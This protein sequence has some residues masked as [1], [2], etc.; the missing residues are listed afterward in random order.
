MESKEVRCGRNYSQQKRGIAAGHMRVVD[1]ISS[2][3]LA[4]VSCSL[5][6]P[7]PDNSFVCVNSLQLLFC[8]T[9]VSS[10]RIKI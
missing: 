4:K 6:L 5:A 9:Q 8:S 1:Y 10:P 2:R 3:I 7:S